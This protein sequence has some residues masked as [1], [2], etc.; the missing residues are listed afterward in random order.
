MFYATSMRLPID[1]ARHTFD[2]VV[3]ALTISPFQ[4]SFLSLT[5]IVILLQ[6]LNENAFIIFVHQ[7]DFQSTSQCLCIIAQGRK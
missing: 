2:I 4:R 1:T 3:P 7:P 5:Y 6:I